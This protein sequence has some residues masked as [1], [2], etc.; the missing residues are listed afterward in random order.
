[1]AEK[2]EK[3][4]KHRS[5]LPAHSAEGTIAGHNDDGEQLVLVDKEGCSCHGK[6][7]RIYPNTDYLDG[8]R[9]RFVLVAM[10]LVATPTAM[11]ATTID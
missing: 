7:I 3:T 10:G 4:T 2:R 5:E 1:M 11:G 9:V 8:T 6:K